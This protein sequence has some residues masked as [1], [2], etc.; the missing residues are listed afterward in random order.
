[1]NEDKKAEEEEEE[2]EVGGMRKFP[3]RGFKRTSFALFN[4]TSPTHFS[5]ISLF[6]LSFS[7][8]L[9]LIPDLPTSMFGR[10]SQLTRHL[11]RPALSFSPAATS[12]LSSS[13]LS[14]LRRT[15]STMT[16]PA[17]V[18]ATKTIHTAAC[19][20]IGDEVLGGKVG[21]RPSSSESTNQL[22]TRKVD[23]T[24]RKT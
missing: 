3:T 2:E 11:S 12:P 15:P 23:I 4:L 16:A 6:T 22:K 8:S 10:L 24:A 14:P 18:N 7:P 17:I 5:N 1:M 13:S 20:I 9:P 19:L 21:G